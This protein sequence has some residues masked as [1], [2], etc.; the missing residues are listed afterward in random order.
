MA[1]ADLIVLGGPIATLNPA[2]P[3]AEALAIKSGRV[4][5]IGTQA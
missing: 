2:G 3:W 5:A 1:D 4:L